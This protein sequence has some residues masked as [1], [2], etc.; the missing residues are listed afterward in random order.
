MRDHWS[1]P[2]DFVAIDG[3]FGVLDLMRAADVADLLGIPVATLVN[4]RASGKGR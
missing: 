1:W 3:L 4:W 2:R